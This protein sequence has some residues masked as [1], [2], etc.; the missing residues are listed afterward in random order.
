M[1]CSLVILVV[2]TGGLWFF[3]LL[4]YFY[5][6]QSVI[7]VGA[8]IPLK[9]FSFPVAFVA[10]IFHCYVWTVICTG[11]VLIVGVCTTYIV[12]IT[13]LLNKELRL[14]RKKYKTNN[15]LR[16]ASNLRTVYRSLQILHQ[17][18]LLNCH[19]GLYL[20]YL[21]WFLVFVPV[22]V[23]FVLIAYWKN[24]G[25]YVKVPLLVGDILAIGYWTFILQVGC[26]LYIGSNKVLRS[27][28]MNDWGF[29]EHNKYMHKFNRSCT[30]ILLCYGRQFV[31]GRKSIITYYRGITRGTFRALLTTR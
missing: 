6:P 14:G 4:Y 5:D 27:W 7:F 3:Y 25:V 2:L 30:P 21:N 22:Y 24:L 10:F 20:V 29:V 28:R 17:Y 16:I 9:F 13:L 8:L 18:I 15:K 31:I 26:F 1:D 11:I 23:T 19:L 12:Y